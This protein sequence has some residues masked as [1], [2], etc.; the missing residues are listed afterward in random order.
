MSITLGAHEKMYGDIVDRRPQC[1][2]VSIRSPAL[3]A[4]A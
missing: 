4:I 1:E 3:E 2:A